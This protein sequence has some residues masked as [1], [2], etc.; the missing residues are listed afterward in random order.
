LPHG[1][2][3]LI[4]DA[5]RLFA[6]HHLE[7]AEEKYQESPSKLDPK[8]VYTL[9]NLATIQIEREDFSA[10]EKNLKQALCA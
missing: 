6:A 3:E 2:P 8:N 9:A 4:A 7:E 5:Q 10:A 1:A